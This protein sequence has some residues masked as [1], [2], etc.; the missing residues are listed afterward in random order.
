[1]QETHSEGRRKWLFGGMAA[2]V[3]GAFGTLTGFAVAFLLPKRKR[4]FEQ[5]IF[6][7]FASAIGAGESRL[8]TLPSGDRMVLV[9]T[10]RRSGVGAIF[11]GF[12]SRCPHLGC[13]VHYAAGDDRY[14]CPCH[15]GVFDKNGKPVS[16]PPA[17]AGQQLA[18]YRIETDG[19]SL[20]AVV[21]LT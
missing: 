8:L 6:V 3:S 9:N 11:Q 5:R 7:G 18:A 12:S 16:G 2:A 20:Y 13:Q 19:N 10:G 15:Q 21:E 4:P 1:M 14:L 17:K